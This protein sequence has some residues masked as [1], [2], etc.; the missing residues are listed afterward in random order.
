[1]SHAKSSKINGLQNPV[2]TWNQ[3]SHEIPYEYQGLIPTF[4]YDSTFLHFL[5]RFRITHTFINV[6]LIRIPYNMSNK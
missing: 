6:L 2:T 5:Q 3:L 4:R 1:M